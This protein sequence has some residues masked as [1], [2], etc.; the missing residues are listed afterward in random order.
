M[1]KEPPA[2]LFRALDFVVVRTPF[3]PVEAY[4]ALCGSGGFLEPQPGR[5]GPLDALFATP[6]E[7]HVRRALRVASDSL[8]A[9]LERGE[10]GDLDDRHAGQL[11]AKLLR[12]LIRMSTRPTPFG[13]FAGVGL[14]HWGRS[15]DLRLGPRVQTRTRPDMAWLM[16]LV[17]AAEGDP[18]VRRH[19]RLVANPSTR[20]Q[21]GRVILPERASPHESSDAQAVAISVRATHV[22]TRA[23]TLARQP[24]AWQKLTDVLL[25]ETPGATAGQVEQLLTELL[26]QTL[27]LT[28]L[29]PPLTCRN[30]ARRV[31]RTLAAISKRSA[32]LDAVLAA[33]AAWDRAA[34]S[35]ATACK[36]VNAARDATGAAE[37]IAAL[38]QVDSALR[39]E[40]ACLTE[41]VGD[42]VARA[43]ELLLSMSPAPHGPAYLD[44]Y[45]RA[46]VSR[47]GHHRRVPL[48]ELLQ[49]DTGLGPP[50]WRGRSDGHADSRSIMRHQMLRELACRATWEHRRV[51]E[52][53]AA[54][55]AKL[56]TWSP[57][58]TSAPASLDLFV[59]LAASSS[60]AVDNGAFQVVVSPQPGASQAG[61]SLGRFSDLLPGAGRL[62]ARIARLEEAGDPDR[63]WAEV[64]YMPRH[65]RSANVAIRPPTR[66]YEIPFCVAPGV[67]SDRVI[68]LAELVIGVRNERFYVHWPRMRRDV[69]PCEAHMLNSTRAPD[70]VRFLADLTRDGVAQLAPFDWGP[71]NGAPF[72]PRVQV[73]RSVLCLAQWTVDR[74]RLPPEPAGTFE[75]A[76]DRWRAEWELPRH[77]YLSS[78]DNRLL[79]DLACAAHREELRRE[80]RAQPAREPVKL[81]E[82]LP[83][84][85]QA[86]LTGPTGHFLAEFAV[87][88]ILRQAA[89]APEPP[90][91][92]RAHPV[93][94]GIDAKLTSAAR[95]RS[96]GSDWLYAKLYCPSVLEDEVIA[97]DVRPFVDRALGDGV[98]DDWFYIRYSDPD[99]HLRLRFK[100]QPDR[101]VSQLFPAL[102]AWGDQLVTDGRCLH[103]GFDTY[104]REVERFGGLR[105]LDLAEAMFCAD[106]RA[107]SE[108]LALENSRATTLDRIT[109][110]VLSV[111]DLLDSVGFTHVDRVSLYRLWVSDRHAVS[112]EYRSRK[113]M[114]RALLGDPTRLS[115]EPG[116]AAV[117]AILAARRRA[118]APIAARWAVLANRGELSESLAWIG[119]SLVHL[120]CNRLLGRDASMEQQTLGLLLR[121]TDGLARAPLV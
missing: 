86:W 118:L 16:A 108:L 112:T 23:L 36:L 104:E 72:L 29:R 70:P 24:I 4:Q 95:L 65:V 89:H 80:L 79:L 94:A 48:L 39:L 85:D 40:R 53:D 14:A 54:V 61:R 21:G 37:P 82:V 68:P 35:D 115:C 32:P 9:A 93:V 22:V 96:P 1:V 33:A 109:L 100:G 25:T 17:Q 46:F 105:G 2:P 15:T 76:L 90:S 42:E 113:T 55:L 30:P 91:L 116:V 11:R 87:P 62:L 38:F 3:L 34:P 77:V 75:S 78:A 56:Q 10:H 119:R 120:H 64:V 49:P 121:V 20:I 73:G 63:I 84:L 27:L 107:A 69:V 71:A 58:P 83:G 12:Y 117:G 52:L 110:G 7:R 50:T 43:A 31:A 18:D 67:A 92:P 111:D 19:L 8:V 60:G 101:L 47:Y 28:D 6:A 44:E 102:C 103:Y 51:I 45:R 106:S 41:R 97:Q 66:K 13:L 59:S 57:T 74:E 99:A 98:A 114:L 88:L 5:I 26:G 81:Q